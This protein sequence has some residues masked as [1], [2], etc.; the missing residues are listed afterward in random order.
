MDWNSRKT[1]WP[2]SVGVPDDLLV[3]ETVPERS[4][5]TDVCIRDL[6]S[7]VQLAL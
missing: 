3:N 2:G 1:D 7:I 5:G 6:D 4:G